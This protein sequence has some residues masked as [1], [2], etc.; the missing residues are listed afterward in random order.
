MKY[1]FLLTYRIQVK[2]GDTWAPYRGRQDNYVRNRTVIDLEHDDVITK[3]SS[4][5]G[6]AEKF[7]KICRRNE[8]EPGERSEHP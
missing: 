6:G 7:L 4:V 5:V 8:A 3:V 2:Y 1:F